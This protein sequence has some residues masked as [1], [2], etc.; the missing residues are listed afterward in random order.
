MHLA[1][2]MFDGVHLGHRVVIRQ[3]V[4][5]VAGRPGHFSAL[6]TFNPHP[7][8]VLYPARATCMLMDLGSR[9]S[10]IHRIGIDMVYVQS[11]T[12]QYARKDAREFVPMLVRI[13]PGL[14]SIHVGENF[15]FGS[16]R[17]GNVEILRESTAACGIELHA[18]ERKVLDGLAI[19][20]S[21]IRSALVEGAIDEVAAMLGEPYTVNGQVARG[22]GV[23][24]QLNF[25]TVNVAWN[26]EVA[27]RYGVYR[28]NLLHAR[29]GHRLSGVAN[30]GLRPTIE[31]ASDP[32]L[33]V[34][35]LEGNS[36]PE[37]GDPVE[38]QLLEFI[39]PELDFGSV[40]SLRLQIEKDIRV[41]RSRLK[42]SGS[43]S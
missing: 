16:G 11:F 29:T 37:P 36:W 17:G 26:P 42:E 10:R 43:A 41:V 21:R 19:S 18:V 32:I 22:K 28:V 14:R 40:D 31:T 25:P 7:S 1:I 35:L 27:P 30:Y 34:H 39:R 13:F 3:A 6:L 4:D 5:A 2:G 33:E 23:G 15:R 9:I 38:I 8:C 12:T 20:S 24:R